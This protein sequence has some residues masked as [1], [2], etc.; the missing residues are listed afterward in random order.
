[1]NPDYS[2]LIQ[3]DLLLARSNKYTFAL[4]D[5]DEILNRVGTKHIDRRYC[6]DWFVDNDILIK[7]D[8]EYYYTGDH[9][10]RYKPYRGYQKIVK[11]VKEKDG[12]PIDFNL[13]NFT[14][15]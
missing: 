7:T 15:D 13:I 6:L 12:L 5:L 14:L 4:Q 3:F 9:I 10:D 2:V 8:S 1:M 11:I